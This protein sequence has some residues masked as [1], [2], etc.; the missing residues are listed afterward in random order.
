MIRRVLGYLAIAAGIG[1]LTSMVV[2]LPP[3]VWPPDP[4][5]S[6]TLREGQL[7]GEAVGYVWRT[8]AA[9]GTIHVSASL[10]G[11]RAV[12]VTVTAGT[13]IHIGDKLGAFGDL[14]TNARVRVIYEVHEHV[15]LANSIE[16]LGR[17]GPMAET[18]GRDVE[19]RV[20][21]APT[22]GFWIDVGVFADP[23]AADALVARLM[24]DEQSVSLET[25]TSR[26]G[27][28]RVLRVQVG[29]FEDEA[30]A[31]AAQRNLRRI[32][33]QASLAAPVW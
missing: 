23:D 27:T 4:D 20:E 11:L 25:V 9:S 10:V 28:H 24:R 16:V 2:T 26:D 15:R 8:N 13:T 29:P 22:V 7:V 33:Y 19:P 3:L 21:H 17:G 18:F 12:P 5:A 30:A 14:N 6:L 32:G 31:L 1:L